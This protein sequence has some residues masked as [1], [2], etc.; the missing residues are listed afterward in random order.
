[1]T[2][3]AR[4]TAIATARRIIFSGLT[5]L[6]VW[7]F[8]IVLRNFLAPGAIESIGQSRPAFGVAPDFNDWSHS[9]STGK[10][11]ADMI[12]LRTGLTLQVVGL[13]MLLAL[14]IAALLLCLGMLVRRV[15]ARP[16][17]LVRTR[18]IL[19]LVFISGGV[20]IPVF[21]WSVL[22]LVF[23]IRS[24]NQLPSTH[25]QVPWWS[26]FSVSLLP[27]WLLI[28]TGHGEQSKWQ[29]NPSIS[30]KQKAAQLGIKLVV[31]LLKL[32]GAIIA[33]AM[34]AGAAPLGNLL[35][36]S[37]SS[38]DLP[39]AFR[40]AWYFAVAVVVVKL[41][42]DLIEIACRPAGAIPGPQTPGETRDRLRTAI[43]KGW[44]IFCF[45]LV[46]VS[47]MVAVIG[48]A[49]APY[50][51]NQVSM[52]D[53]LAPPSAQHILG[54][55]NVGRDTL[56][57]LLYGIRTTLGVSLL[58]V[59]ALAAIAAGWGVLARWAS[60]ASNWVGEAVEDAIML[61]RDVLCAFPW[62]VLFLMLITLTGPGFLQV[63]FIGGLVLLP[64]AAGMMQEAYRS[65][66][67]G[68]S[69]T[70]AVLWA[71]AVMLLFAVAGGILY[72]SAISYLGVGVPP[73]Q[74][75]LGSLLSG[76]GRV[77]MI[78]APW[79]ALA[80]SIV[81]SLLVFVWVMAGDAVLERLGFRSKAVWSKVME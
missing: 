4:R 28:Q 32:V 42:A 60:K 11:V 81:L 38:M 18:T 76:S 35:M 26:V 31:R 24:G 21:V 20:S 65:P 9:W 67:V 45:I 80:P 13:G 7:V 57:R 41:A 62:L 44:L 29:D 72:T 59:A 70:G 27:A 5:I 58:S 48:P 40:V 14:G 74:P 69:P 10:P 15:T 73:P 50:G 68:R 66:P 63:A 36:D 1:M 37:L 39:V 34:L 3:T 55:D 33:V 16:E 12:N 56:T 49:L 79:I 30:Y 2:A 75:E 25:G 64:R 43:P 23:V 8:L 71:I 61:P 51:V 6:G 52:T 78:Q 46:F 53:R 17:W 19:R 54:T 77:Y 47:V 22:Y